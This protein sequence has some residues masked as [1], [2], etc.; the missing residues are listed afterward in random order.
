MRNSENNNK[1]INVFSAGISRDLSPDLGQIKD[2][3]IFE[4]RNMSD[5]KDNSLDGSR[6]K[7]KGETVIYGTTAYAYT[8]HN[9]FSNGGII[10]LTNWAIAYLSEVMDQNKKLFSD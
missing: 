6:Q 9:T 7:I 8:P 4:S 5:R 2:G 3:S 10:L 1:K